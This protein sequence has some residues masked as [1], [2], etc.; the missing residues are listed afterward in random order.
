MCNWLDRK[1]CGE[2]TTVIDELY[3][4]LLLYIILVFRRISSVADSLHIRFRGEK[5][6][7]S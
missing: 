3:M 4:L 5:L 2:P 1:L 6:S 7:L